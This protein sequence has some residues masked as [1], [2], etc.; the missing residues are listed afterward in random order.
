M[1]HQP[2]NTTRRSLLPL[3]LTLIEL[4]VAIVIMVTVLAAVVPV[5]SPN[6]DDRKIREATR[7]LSSLLSQAQAQAARDG[8]PFGIQFTE[9]TIG[10]PSSPSSRSG[11]AI[12]ASI[13]SEPPAFTGFSEWSRVTIMPTPD[14][15]E[16][17]TDSPI[18]NGGTRF[19]PKYD[20]YPLWNLVFT[21]YGQEDPIPPRTIRV[22]DKIDVAGN[23]FLVIDDGES[24]EG[25]NQVEPT[26]GY[27]MSAP[28]LHAIW[29]NNGGQLFSP[30]P[31]PFKFRRLPTPTS[32]LP[33][34]FPRGIGV[35]LQASGA[36][37]VP[38]LFSLDTGGETTVTV[39]FSP[40]GAIDV[41]Y[42]NNRLFTGVNQLFLLLA[43]VENGN[44][45][46]SQDPLDYDF[47]ANPST[48]EADLAQR[49]SRINW[50]NAES[51]WVT[52]A[53]SGRVVTAENNIF[54]PQ[55]SPYIDDPD[56]DVQRRLQITHSR[57][58]ARTLLGSGGR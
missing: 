20:R 48:D 17:G 40:T 30:G 19:L 51:R 27:L 35:D 23:E 26:T 49:R 47:V 14:K 29:L 55:Q 44:D 39:M 16:Y 54:N 33:L 25:A 15:L 41:V 24:V 18:A 8:R 5:L 31:K 38:D 7:Q 34:Q 45:G 6:N 32:D 56:L 2:A 12:E 46:V 57:N 21:L 3:G 52:V 50:L 43:R 9:A 28:T 11:M 36:N 37:G 58:N 10:D 13:V 22:G 42:R 1:T 53:Q 4:L